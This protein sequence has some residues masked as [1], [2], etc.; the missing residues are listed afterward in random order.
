[1]SLLIVT[2]P[3]SPPVSEEFLLNGFENNDDI[4][5]VFSRDNKLVIKRPTKNFKN[6]YKFYQENCQH[7]GVIFCKKSP[8]SSVSQNK[9]SGKLFVLTPNLVVL[10]EGFL[11]SPKLNHTKKSEMQVLVDKILKSAVKLDENIFKLES[12]Q[13]FLKKIFEYN[14]KLIFLYGNGDSVIIN[15]FPGDWI[16][17][18]WYSN[19]DY[20]YT[21]RRGAAFHKVYP[22]N[23]NIKLLPPRRQGITWRN[24]PDLD[25]DGEFEKIDDSQYYDQTEGDLIAEKEQEEI[26]IEMDE[27]LEKTIRRL[28]KQVGGAGD[29]DIESGDYNYGKQLHEFLN[30][31]H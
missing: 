19:N 14:S 20:K 23:G 26:D 10:Y 28:H 22:P 4:G 9:D 29:R 8:Y 3:Q 12:V 15:D 16:N 31:F 24:D 27:E 13:S 18:V 11:F 30:D 6:F 25:R 17:N 5:M 2:K 21:W 1:M 7:P